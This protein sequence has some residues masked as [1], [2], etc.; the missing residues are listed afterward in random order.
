MYDNCALVSKKMFKKE[1]IIDKIKRLITEYPPFDMGRN[2]LETGANVF[3]VRFG[4]LNN[5]MYIFLV[6]METLILCGF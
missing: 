3:S 6:K 4:I 1:Y 5:H 2:R